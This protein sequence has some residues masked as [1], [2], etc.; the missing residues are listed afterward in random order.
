M[1]DFKHQGLCEKITVTGSVHHVEDSHG[2][3]CIEKSSHKKTLKNEAILAKTEQVLSK[4]DG[5]K[6]QRID[7]NM[8]KEV[9]YIQDLLE[10]IT[11]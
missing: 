6:T 7:E 5:Y 8:V 2:S 4:L 1:F 11:K 9:F 3:I 10:E